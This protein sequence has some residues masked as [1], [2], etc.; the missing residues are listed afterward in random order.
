MARIPKEETFCVLA[1]EEKNGL[2]AVLRLGGCSGHCGRHPVGSP[3]PPWLHNSLSDSPESTRHDYQ[4]QISNQWPR[5]KCLCGSPKPS[6]WPGKVIAGTLPQRSTA[7][8]PLCTCL[9]THS[10]SHTH[11]P[12]LPHE[13]AKRGKVTHFQ[14]CFMQFSPLNEVK[15]ILLPKPQYGRAQIKLC[16]PQAELGQPRQVCSLYLLGPDSH[17]RNSVISPSGPGPGWLGHSQASRSTF[18]GSPVAR[19]LRTGRF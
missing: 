6:T 13:M 3:P 17:L 4:T 16:L 15:L 5:E 9:H 12:S 7:L 19:V 1:T 14:L 2:R 18:Q 11:A 8:T 10:H